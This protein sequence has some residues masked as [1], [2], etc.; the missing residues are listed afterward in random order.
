MNTTPIHSFVAKFLAVAGLSMTLAPQ[1]V[2]AAP[3]T[4][5]QREGHG[6]NGCT[7]LFENGGYCWEDSSSETGFYCKEDDPSAEQQAPDEEV[8]ASYDPVVFTPEDPGS[9][10]GVQ[11]LEIVICGPDD[12]AGCFTWAIEDVCCEDLGLPFGEPLSV[13]GGTITCYD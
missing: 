1:I 5:C 7:D 11:A 2:L 10:G 4:Y 8:V 9:G 6:A 12:G 13:G 3:P